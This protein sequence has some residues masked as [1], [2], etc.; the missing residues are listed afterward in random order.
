M[1]LLSEFNNSRFPDYKI[2]ESEICRPE[3]V[4]FDNIFAV[5][6]YGRVICERHLYVFNHQVVVTDQQAGSKLR[7]H[8][9][10]TEPRILIAQHT[11]SK[12]QV[13][14]EPESKQVPW[15]V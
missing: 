9:A 15:G 10:M 5:S 13:W 2:L 12:I 6:G 8:P 7:I 3:W 11:E 14:P 1:L 4:S